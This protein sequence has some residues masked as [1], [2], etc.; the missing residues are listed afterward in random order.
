MGGCSA[1]SAFSTTF[2]T[3]ADDE[4]EVLVLRDDT[5][6]TVSSPIWVDGS[7]KVPAAQAPASASTREILRDA[8][9]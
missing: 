5:M 3:K 1:W 7:R 8:G 2:R 4:N 9:Y 6:L